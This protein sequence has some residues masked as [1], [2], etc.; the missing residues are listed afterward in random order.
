MSRI[1]T[2]CAVLALGCAPMTDANHDGIVDGVRTPNS[3]SQ[4][5]PSTPVGSISG[6]VVNS[7]NAGIEGVQVV[8]VLGNGA[9]AS[10]T[11]KTTTNTE[12]AYMF[13]EV[14]GGSGAQLLFSKTGYSNARLNGAVPGSSGNFP[15]NDG[16][17]NA[18]VLTLVQLNGSLK[19][20]VYTAQGRPAKGA[21]AF[22][23]VQ[24]TA[25]QTFA[26][27]YG[28]ACGNFSG[29]AD[30]DENGLLTFTG[31][32]DV[33]ELARIGPG[34]SYILTVG[35]LDE[36][37]DGRADAL[38]TLAAYRAIDLFTNPDR[39]IIL[40]DAHTG[41]P[42]SILAASLDSFGSAFSA[43]YRN[44]VKAND[45]VTIVFNQP[46]TQ[47]D[48]TRLVRVVAEDCQTLVP[49][50][51][52]QRAPNVLS[53]APTASW[54]LGSRYN[55]IVR[56]TGLDSGAT[57]EFIGY[58]FAID[59]TAP[60]PLSPTASF[61]VRKFPGNTMSSGLQPN[62]SLHVVFDT[63]IIAQ[64]GPAA[65]VIA[66]FDLNGDGITGGMTGNG[67][68]NALGLAA[69]TGFALSNA[70]QTTATDPALGTF[71]CKLSGYSS[72]W[73]ISSTGSVSFPSFV[74]ANTGMRVV[75]AKDQQS[76]DSYQTAWGSPVASD[77]NGTINVVP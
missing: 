18:G 9:D 77:V 64:G 49:V 50:S 20:R 70:E 55:I 57:R 61:Q 60:R 6:V 36:D 52:T 22:L 32:P 3:I 76:A 33:S 69:T 15:I 19:F 7:L 46:I 24:Q 67:E 16:N 27:V 31:T 54:T 14:P 30:V 51:V 68:F 12:G 74:P 17:G 48:T 65:R 59:A 56:V 25:F 11:Y 35:A 10:R 66:N 8:M 75:F 62:D 4:V 5:A 73:L 28:S 1:L 63:P 40:A 29:A 42:L 39:T 44:A 26:G 43:P 45:P 71:T 21:K 72:R 34:I 13:K 47:V 41:A 23:E 58:F 2:V 38:G 53:I 37:M